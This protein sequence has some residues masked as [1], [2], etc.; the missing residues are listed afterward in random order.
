MIKIL[1]SGIFRIALVAVAILLVALS[2]IYIVS[3]VNERRDEALL[4]AVGAA[5]DEVSC[6]VEGYSRTIEVMANMP[7][8]RDGNR[9][10][11][12]AFMAS[13]EPR[14]R[15]HFEYLFFIDKDGNSVT[16]GGEGDRLFGRAYY[17]TLVLDRAKV[18]IIT[19]PFFLPNMRSKIVF[20]IARSVK[21]DN[22]EV[23]GVL[24]AVINID[25]LEII[26]RNEREEVYDM[27]VD[28]RGRFIKHRNPAM[29]LVATL[30]SS[31]NFGIYGLAQ[32]SNK[33][34]ETGQGF[35]YYTNALLEKR[36]LLFAPV[37]STPGWVYLVSIP[38]S[39]H[40]R[41]AMLHIVASGV[42]C[43]ILICV[44]VLSSFL[45][46]PKTQDETVRDSDSTYD[47]DLFIDE[48]EKSAESRR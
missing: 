34:L 7:I 22:N 5:A 29:Q 26:T 46:Q 36:V 17:K 11:I 40:D 3:Q 32:E 20:A 30:Q 19:D 37:E 16:E 2:T 43:L 48:E 39:L 21:D 35:A 33:I 18:E 9:K 44:L 12:A 1:T 6:R 23:V 45:K 25:K 42:L 27:L 13:Y 28:G 38:K 4:T 14:L 47:A 31:P 41:S 10:T 24:F 15:N 8:F